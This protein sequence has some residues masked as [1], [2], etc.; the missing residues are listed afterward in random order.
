MK[1]ADMEWELV[2]EWE[3]VRKEEEEEERACEAA[4]ARQWAAVVLQQQA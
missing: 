4:E 2:V 1:I 3:R